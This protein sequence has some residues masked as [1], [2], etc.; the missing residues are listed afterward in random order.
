M[1]NKKLTQYTRV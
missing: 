1:L